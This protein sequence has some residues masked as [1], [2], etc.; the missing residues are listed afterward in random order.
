LCEL[1]TLTVYL[2]NVPVAERAGERIAVEIE[3][4]K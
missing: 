1:V 4:G 3:T 2:A